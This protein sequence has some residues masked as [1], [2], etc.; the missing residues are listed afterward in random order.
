M[1]RRL[2]LA[3]QRIE[4]IGRCNC[5]RRLYF[6][7][8]AQLLSRIAKPF[9]VS[10]FSLHI[11][12]WLGRISARIYL[13]RINFEMCWSI[14]SLQYF[15][16]TPAVST[17]QHPPLLKQSKI[18]RNIKSKSTLHLSAPKLLTSKLFFVAGKNSSTHCKFHI[19]LSCHYSSLSID[20]TSLYLSIP[21]NLF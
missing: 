8:V 12:L 15:V 10:A 1:E 4:N 18:N 17:N 13:L 2:P 14:L 9:D 5:L 21:R 20:S 7:D 16:F 3:L 11:A 6:I 19:K